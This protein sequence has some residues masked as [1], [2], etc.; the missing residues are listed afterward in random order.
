MKEEG[1]TKEPYI[2]ICF[3]AFTPFFFFSFLLLL[4]LLLCVFLAYRI[5]V[6]CF[7]AMYIKQ[8]FF[9]SSLISLLFLPPLN[10]FWKVSLAFQ[11]LC[12]LLSFQL[13]A[14]C[15]FLFPFTMSPV[16][17]CASHSFPLYQTE[18]S[19][20]SAREA[21]IFRSNASA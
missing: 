8:V 10:P 1:K 15:S 4:L 3:P 2:F 13:L 6:V 16:L 18:N 19:L 17:S 21:C 14:F 12:V 7:H 9:S 20:K 5:S 11:Q